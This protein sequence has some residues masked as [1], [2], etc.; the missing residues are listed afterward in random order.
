MLNSKTDRLSVAV[1]I[2]AT[3][4]FI[5]C[6]YLT[7]V[8][9][10]T[11]EAGEYCLRG[12]QCGAVLK[13]RFSQLFGVPASLVGAVGYAV[14]IIACIRGGLEKQRSFII[15]LA[16]AGV[17]ISAYLSWAEF[18]VI[19]EICP[20]CLASALIVLSIWILSVTGA[21][22]TQ[23][24]S[25]IAIIMLVA[26]AGYASSVLS[27]PKPAISANR[28]SR[29]LDDFQKNLA[30]HLKENGAIMYGAFNCPACNRQKDYFGRYAK[31]LEYVECH[32]AG[33]NANPRLCDEKKIKA[34]P[35]WEMDGALHTGAM[36]L[37]KLAELS[38]YKK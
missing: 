26:I 13:S 14:I 30:R 4:G 16:S 1:V 9:Y 28:V 38:R 29:E 11:G 31:E 8:Y 17:G 6:F 21:R 15:G 3:L 24:L 33:K 27:E 22:V 32:P 35:T 25:G 37:K 7:A 36:T 23:I 18:F 5:V 10:T 20:F 34:Y 19:Q 12:W 2:L